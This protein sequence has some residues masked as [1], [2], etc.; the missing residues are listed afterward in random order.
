MLLRPRVPCRSSGGA[1]NAARLKRLPPAT[2]GSSRYMTRQDLARFLDQG[3]EL[4]FVKQTDSP[5]FL[6]WILLRK[7]IPNQRLLSLVDPV[8]EPDVLAKEQ[9][10]VGRPYQV[11]VIE[12]ASDVFESGRYETEGDF[13]MNEVRYFSSL[14]EV[15]E[16]VG[17]FGYSLESIKWR[18]EINAP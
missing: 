2:A 6:G 4:G 14:D 11:H 13:R 9:M 17:S 1:E 16:F 15:E 8:E 12:L 5:D 10:L 7:R 3:H 18:P